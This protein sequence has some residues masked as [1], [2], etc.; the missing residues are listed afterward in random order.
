[1]NRTDEI[2]EKALQAA[3]PA[4][5]KDGFCERV[6]LRLPRAK[7]RV[8]AR[9]ARRLSLAGAA[10]IGSLVTLFLGAPVESLFAGY[11]EAGGLTATLLGASVV[12]GI[13]VVPVLWLICTEPAK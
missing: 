8:S 6:L 3:E 13:V 9:L 12:V 10:C 5:A 2:I 1:M 4:I 11:L 7:R